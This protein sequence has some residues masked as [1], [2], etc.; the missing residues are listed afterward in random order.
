MISFIAKLI[1]AINSNSR[2]SELASGI[3]FGFL[4]GEGAGH[5]PLA[6]GLGVGGV[7]GGV[8]A[9]AVGSGQEARRRR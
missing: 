4:L 2:P 1:V 6:K 7:G 8:V 5:V 3:A 9:D